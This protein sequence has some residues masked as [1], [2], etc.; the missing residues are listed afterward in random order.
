MIINYI[1]A[2]CFGTAVEGQNGTLGHIKVEVPV[3]PECMWGKKVPEG[4]ECAIVHARLFKCLYGNKQD[5]KCCPRM[6]N[7]TNG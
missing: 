1:K 7:I 5:K 6:W 2:S 4:F 3:A